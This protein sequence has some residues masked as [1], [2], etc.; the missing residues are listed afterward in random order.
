MKEEELIR[1]VWEHRGEDTILWATDYP[2]AFARG[3]NL[4]EAL[5]KLPADLRE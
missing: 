5:A 1:C 4:N 3:S 2:G